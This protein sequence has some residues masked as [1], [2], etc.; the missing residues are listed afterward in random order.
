MSRARREGEGS[1]TRRAMDR[2]E[3]HT[4]RNISGE[5]RSGTFQAR[6]APEHF[7]QSAVWRFFAGGAAFF[8]RNA[9]HLLSREARW[10]ISSEACFAR[11]APHLF[12]A[13]RAAIFFR[14]RPARARREVIDHMARWGTLVSRRRGTLSPGAGR[15]E[16]A[17]KATA[18]PQPTGAE[19]PAPG[20]SST[21][22]RAGSGG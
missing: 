13:R 9:P 18:L 4:L 1:R 8:A 3:R 19:A 11:G 5:A 16:A 14:V 20:C 21:T 12:R 10:S 15:V 22:E 7:K 17:L 2:F 6:R